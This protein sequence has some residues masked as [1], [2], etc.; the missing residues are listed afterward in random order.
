M[1]T[2]I[3]TLK[4]RKLQWLGHTLRH[5]SPIQIVLE[6]I[7]TRKKGR[8]RPKTNF[9]SQTCGELG[10]KYIDVKM[11]IKDWEKWRRVVGREYQSVD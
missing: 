1:I 5:D 7:Y 10:L 2:M 6:G 9:I 11:K 8:G 4:V 3:H